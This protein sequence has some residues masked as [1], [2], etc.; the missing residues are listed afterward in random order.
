MIPHKFG[1]R[2]SLLVFVPQPRP[3]WLPASLVGETRIFSIGPRKKEGEDLPGGGGLGEGVHVV[4]EFDTGV[5]GRIVIGGLQEIGH[6]LEQEGGGAEEELPRED[7]H[8]PFLSQRK[9]K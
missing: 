4:V 6:V 7:E 1:S 2:L 3:L 5:E 9:E 8:F